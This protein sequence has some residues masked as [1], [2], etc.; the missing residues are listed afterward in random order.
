MLPAVICRFSTTAHY[1][2]AGS[3]TH[4]KLNGKSQTSGSAKI[5]RQVPLTGLSDIVIQTGKQRKKRGRMHIKVHSD[6]PS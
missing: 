3:L 6:T 2:Y 1:T 5:S 4:I